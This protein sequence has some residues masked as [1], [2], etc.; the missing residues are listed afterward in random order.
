ME[1]ERYIQNTIRL[2]IRKRCAVSGCGVETANPTNA[3]SS[4]VGSSSFL[5][6]EVCFRASLSHR[7]GCREAAVEGIN[8]AQY[9]FPH[10][11]PFG[12][13]SP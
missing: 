2:L 3:E 7:G 5:K 6:S 11:R 12:P 13:P 9:W 1:Y 4:E 8:I 10:P